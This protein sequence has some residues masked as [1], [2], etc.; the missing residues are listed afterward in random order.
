MDNCAQNRHKTDAVDPGS[1]WEYNRRLVEQL[2]L[3]AQTANL[4]RRSGIMRG[5]LRS[6]CMSAV[7]VLTLGGCINVS[8][9]VTI[10][11]DG[12]G[13][14]VET[15]YMGAACKEMMQQMAGMGGGNAKAGEALPPL[16]ED[17]YRAAAGKMGADVT[18]VSAKHV[19]DGKGNTGVEITYAFKDINK[20][21]IGSEPE[22]PGPPGMGGAP[23]QPAPAEKQEQ[24]TFTFTKG[25][26]NTLVIHN[27]K[28][29]ATEKPEGA[30]APG[31]PPPA[32][33]DKPK[34][35]EVAEIKQMFGDF[36]FY[37]AVKIAGTVSKTNATHVEDA[38]GGKKN[39]ITLVDMNVG[40]MLTLFE[41]EKKL[42][43]LMALG[44][45]NDMAKAK[46]TL[47]DLPGIKVELNEKIEIEF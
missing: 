17:K 5:R 37:T 1:L 7:L 29:K 23:G 22:K 28:L 20:L 35:E 21:K 14:I 42:A 41:D 10:E 44:P 18:Y 33:G 3:E 30:E 4:A 46:E 15:T 47:K 32:D 34:P 19:K 2:W 39:L 45:M 11:K 36:R 43:E 40:K 13:T 16:E 25:T 12:S 9:V 26:P 31:M 6:V 38:D 27:P 24:V 8:R